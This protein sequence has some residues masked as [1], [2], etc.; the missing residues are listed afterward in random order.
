MLDRRNYFWKLFHRNC[1]LMEFNSARIVIPYLRDETVCGLMFSALTIQEF[2][3][4]R[5]LLNVYERF[6]KY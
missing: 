1:A 5:V 6:L 3:T 4:T 2:L